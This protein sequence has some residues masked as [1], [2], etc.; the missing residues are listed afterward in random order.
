MTFKPREYVECP[1]A[2]IC[3]LCQAECQGCEAPLRH[4]CQDCEICES[5]VSEAVTKRA[6]AVVNSHPIIL[7]ISGS[8][9]SCG[10][11]VA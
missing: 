7:S 11:N 8:R 5:C 4:I 3:G 10:V 2:A 9:E 1:Q 6:G